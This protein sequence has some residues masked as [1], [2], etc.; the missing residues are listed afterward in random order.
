MNIEV[1]RRYRLGSYESRGRSPLVVVTRIEP[2]EGSFYDD[3]QEG[4]WYS[5]GVVYYQEVEAGLKVT[6]EQSL[7]YA[8]DFWSE[9]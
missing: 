7:E 6:D 3:H 2:D 4:G 1:G 8:Q 9:A 5:R